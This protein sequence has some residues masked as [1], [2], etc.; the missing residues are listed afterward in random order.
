MS[1]RLVHAGQ[2]DG[3]RVVSAAEHRV[4]ARAIA[5]LYEGQVSV[6]LFV[7]FRRFVAVGV[8]S[9]PKWQPA[10]EE[11]GSHNRQRPTEPASPALRHGLRRRTRHGGRSYRGG[12]A[13]D[14]DGA[15]LGGSLPI[16]VV[17]GQRTVIGRSAH[18]ATGTP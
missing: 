15:G 5:S 1:I 17:G 14:H 12:R 16:S 10:E 8:P 9:E 7:R 3:A 6:D 13:K 11:Q 18:S 4:G 2:L